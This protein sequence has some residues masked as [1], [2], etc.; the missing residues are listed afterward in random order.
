MPQVCTVIA[1]KKVGP[2]TNQ[3][4]RHWSWHGLYDNLP[5][6]IDVDKFK[7]RCEMRGGV[8]FLI[9]VTFMVGCSDGKYQSAE[10]VVEL[11]VSFNDAGWDGETVPKAGQCHDCGG[12]GSSPALRVSNIPAG[13]DLVVVQF[14]DKS[15]P[16]LSRDGGHGAIR[17]RIDDQTAFVARSVPEQTFD[18]PEGVEM[19]SQHRAP[20]GKP[21]AYLAPCGCGNGNEYEA[22]ILALKSAAS[23]KNLV[24]G[25][26][27]IMLGKF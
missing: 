17:F 16:G 11:A 6:R 13:T 18:L 19:E 23:G 14:N 5:V 24:L 15:M 27:R 9:F 1:E 2:G 8:L 22:T 7:G 20:V 21:G 3:A 4:S 25:K 26:G 10:N 12:G